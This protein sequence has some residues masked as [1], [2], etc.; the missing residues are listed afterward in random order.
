MEDLLLDLL[1][2]KKLLFDFIVGS[3]EVYLF[4]ADIS[5]FQHK[6]YIISSAQSLASISKPKDRIR[7]MS[8]HLLVRKCIHLNQV[9]STRPFSGCVETE[10]CH[11][12]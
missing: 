6:I 4:N 8:C 10:M 11:L 7:R 2:R 5:H 9:H 12:L 3:N 1:R